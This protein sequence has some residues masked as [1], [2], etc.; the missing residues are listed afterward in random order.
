M[1]KYSAVHFFLDE[2]GRFTGTSP[3]AELALVGGVLLFGDY[4]PDADARLKAIL[5]RRLEAAGGQFPT[6]LHF[7]STQLAERLPDFLRG[8][9]EELPRWCQETR[10]LYGISL[11]HAS[12]LAD[13]NHGLLSERRNDY[14]YLSMLW[15]LVE[16]LVF[17]DEKVLER[18]APDASINLHVANRAYVFDPQ[19]QS[20][21]ELERL[22]Y[23]VSPDRRQS[24]RMVVRSI[25][26]EGDL[27]TM[28]R[29]AVR[30]RW[31][32]VPV[33][34]GEIRVQRLDYE[35]G[36]SPAALYLADLY[37]GLVR[38]GELGRMR[39]FRPRATPEALLASFRRLQYGPWLEL[40]ALKQAALNNGNLDDYIAA[41]D[42][43]DSLPR[44]H[45]DTFEPIERRQ[46]KR[47]AELLSASAE[48]V[49]ALLEKACHTIDLPGQYDAGW[50]AAERAWRWLIQPPLRAE[51]LYLQARLSHANH[52]GHVRKAD[53]VWQ[54]YERSEPELGSLGS[55]GLRLRA[56][57]RNRRAVHLIDSFRLEEAEKVINGVLDDQEAVQ[58]VLRRM[59][60]GSETCAVNRELGACYGTLGQVHAFLGGQERQDLA[61]EVFVEACRFFKRAD[62]VE[63]QCV[64]LGH[65]ACDRGP[66]G[67]TDWRAV[68]QKLPALLDPNP[69]SGS[70][71][72]Y[73]LALQIKGVLLFAPTTAVLKY[74]ER[75]KEHR[76]IEQFEMEETRLHPFGLIHQAMGLLS[77]RAWRETG[78]NCHRADALAAFERAIKH[79]KHK[80]SGPLLQCLGHF[81]DVRRALFEIES[82]PQQKSRVAALERHFLTLR[83]TLAE[84]FG[85]AAWSAAEETRSAGYFSRLDPGDQ[86]P[87]TERAT[88]VLAGIRFNYW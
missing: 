20:V 55:E 30:M 86:Y 52:T 41:S 33:R 42:Q 29:M 26:R 73:L 15:S 16:H 21:E 9:T 35:N 5:K 69:I 3:R 79:L 13:P 75:W 17:V 71:Q 43:Y 25:L 70:G 39:H 50:R 32:D 74:L 12:D 57:L 82:E 51:M 38:Q 49:V 46:Q 64:Y 56:E 65:L 8:V 31:G 62:D 76:P 44:Q 2:S 88:R 81:A 37:L 11:R 27:L 7:S 36:N 22:G 6:E 58:Q 78:D 80:S 53:E 61:K 63:R 45:L 84:H 72:Q 28:L 24:G 54:A 40:M 68:L 83:G 18:L 85:D 66:A 19:R 87:V 77:A 67:E 4:D 34:L 14:R 47:A 60:A 23:S 48:R 10:A 59:E 1:T